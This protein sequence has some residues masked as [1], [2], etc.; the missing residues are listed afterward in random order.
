MGQAYLYLLALLFV[1]FVAAHTFA[2]LA[3]SKGYQGGKA[4]RYPILLMIAAISAAVLLFLGA[5]LLGLAMPHW[6]NPLQVVFHV[7]NWF[8]IAVNLLVLNLAYKNM[9]A[10]PDAKG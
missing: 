9:K 6:Q 7:G 3:A 1:G 2:R 4:K 5:I 8:V 10:A